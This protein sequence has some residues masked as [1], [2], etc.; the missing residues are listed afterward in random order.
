LLT[1]RSGSILPAMVFHLL[2]NGLL[3]GVALLPRFGYTDEAVPFQPFFHPAVAVTFTLL[4]FLLL[5][6]VRA[7]FELI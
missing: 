6:R 5:M 3:I 4:A 2:Y 1:T 7:Y